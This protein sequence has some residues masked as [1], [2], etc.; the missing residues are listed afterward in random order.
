MR[1]R[2]H[3][4]IANG[5]GK[6]VLDPLRKDIPNGL[7]ENGCGAVVVEN[8]NP[9]ESTDDGWTGFHWYG[10]WYIKVD[11][12]MIVNQNV[13]SFFKKPCRWFLSTGVGSATF[14]NELRSKISQAIRDGIRN[15]EAASGWGAALSMIGGAASLEGVD[16]DHV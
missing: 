15:G 13:P 6:S 9:Q 12:D 10:V 1:V 5:C 4:R 2:I 7:R 11:K 16:V 3:L 14:E 8:D